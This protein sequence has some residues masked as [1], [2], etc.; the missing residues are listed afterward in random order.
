MLEIDILAYS[1]QL[2]HALITTAEGNWLLTIVYGS[3]IAEEKGRLWQSL[4]MA[5]NLHEFP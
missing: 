1:S 5:S 2:I 3:P 4:N